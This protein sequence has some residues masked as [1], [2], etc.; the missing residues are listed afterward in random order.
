MKGKI[1]SLYFNAPNVSKI[2]NRIDNPGDEFSKNVR[3]IINNVV[4][5]VLNANSL[6][7]KAK[8]ASELNKLVQF[9][10]KAYKDSVL[11]VENDYLTVLFSLTN[12]GVEVE[13]DEVETDEVE[14]YEVETHSNVA[15]DE[16][17]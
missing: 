13:T 9:K 10:S 17:E 2:R 6:Y 3:S 5:D 15:D 14:T 7:M 4:A 8:I 11:N 1:S 16:F 12:Q